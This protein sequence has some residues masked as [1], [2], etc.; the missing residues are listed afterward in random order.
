MIAIG[1]D[2]HI[3][4]CDFTALSAEGKILA[5]GVFKTSAI[6]FRE[7]VANIKG[8]NRVIIIEQGPL[9]DW[10]RRI[11]KP[12]AVKVVVAETRR[13]RWISQ[14]SIKNDRFDATKLARLFLGGFI[15]EVVQ[16][17][18][19][20]EELLRITMHHHDLTKQRTQVKNKLKAKFRQEGVRASGDSVFN[21]NK[22]EQWLSAIAH[23]QNIQ[24]SVNNLYDQMDLLNEQIKETDRRLAL[25][26]RRYSIVK[27]LAEEF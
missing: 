8:P 7:M 25:L 24:W 15:K 27:A 22:R 19:R 3:E 21:A 17:N 10:I 18:E 11:L 9:T 6:N 13:N 1:I 2:T 26:A 16:R 20:N 23:N 5:E 12:T 4:T 14:D